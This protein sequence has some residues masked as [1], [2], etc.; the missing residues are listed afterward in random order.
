MIG[1]ISKY[2]EIMTNKSCDHGIR[3]GTKAANYNVTTALKD[4]SDENQ[5]SAA[6]FPFRPDAP[7]IEKSLNL[8]T[9]F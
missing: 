8:F 7:F 2:I 9:V 6:K 5:F 4:A 3:R 1:N